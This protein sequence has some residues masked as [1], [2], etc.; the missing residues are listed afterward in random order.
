MQQLAHRTLS[1]DSGWTAAAAWRAATDAA[2]C[3]TDLKELLLRC[4]WNELLVLGGK[5]QQHVQAS[6]Y[7]SFYGQDKLLPG[8]QD[9]ADATAAE[10]IVAAV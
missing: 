4:S 8:C 5:K 9:T 1:G 10:V 2:C 7:E 6:K 3:C